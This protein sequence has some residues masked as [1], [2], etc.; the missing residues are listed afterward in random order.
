MSIDKKSHCLTTS[1][2]CTGGNLTTDYIPIV[3]DGKNK[4]RKY[5]PA[6]CAR[7]QTVPDW[8]NGIVQ[9]P[10]STRCLVMDGQ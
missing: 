10:K 1:A 9:T 8:Y 7:L 2:L 5:T 6:E 4:L 3:V